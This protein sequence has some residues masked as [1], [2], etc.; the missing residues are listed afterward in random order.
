MTAA[1]LL[2]KRHGQLLAKHPGATLE[3]HGGG[4]TGEITEDE[5]A[6]ALEAGESVVWVARDRNGDNVGQAVCYAGQVVP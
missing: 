5:G 3:L 4:G 2:I 1:Q 6:Q